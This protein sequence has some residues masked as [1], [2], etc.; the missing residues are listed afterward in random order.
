M[1]LVVTESIVE[2]SEI[3]GLI[4]GVSATFGPIGMAVGAVLIIGESVYKAVGRLHTIQSVVHLSNR[5]VVRESLRAF[6]GITPSRATQHAIQ[7][8]GTTPMIIE[9]IL[10]FLNSNQHIGWYIMP[11]WSGEEDGELCNNNV[12]LDEK[13]IFKASNSYPV[14]T[15]GLNIFCLT[16]GEI[17]KSWWENVLDYSFMY[18][19]IL[20]IREIYNPEKEVI[21][22]MYVHMHKCDRCCP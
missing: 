9:E 7:L 15:H 4:E 17:E 1:A 16:P 14:N 18:Q 5:Q 20:F 21:Y 22:H 11:T 13:H 3:F 10:K 19:T 12:I 6:L 2:I 8:K